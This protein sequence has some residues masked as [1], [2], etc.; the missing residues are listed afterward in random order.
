[1]VAREGQNALT[2]KRKEMEKKRK[3][4]KTKRKKSNNLKSGIKQ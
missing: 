1:M 3:E 4:R 2:L